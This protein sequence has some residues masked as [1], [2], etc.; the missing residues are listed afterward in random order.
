MEQSQWELW[1]KFGAQGEVARAQEDPLICTSHFPALY[2]YRQELEGFLP[3]QGA[4]PGRKPDQF[5]DVS[6]P[7]VPGPCLLTFSPLLLFPSS[8]VT[9]YLNC[10]PLWLP[11]TCFTSGSLHDPLFL[12]SFNFPLLSSL[13]QILCP[14][15]LLGSFLPPMSV[16]E[17]F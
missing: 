8:L 9:S 13:S 16:P 17:S 7:R 14:L 6:D 10:S 1:G 15:L 2:S 11:P 3:S 5:M 4:A 12:S